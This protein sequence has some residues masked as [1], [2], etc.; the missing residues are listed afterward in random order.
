[1]GKYDERRATEG[2]EVVS[3][4]WGVRGVLHHHTPYRAR[5][6]ISSLI[7]SVSPCISTGRSLYSRLFPV[8]G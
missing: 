6:L 2:G 5:L 4:R 7:T 1:M 3:P 8:T